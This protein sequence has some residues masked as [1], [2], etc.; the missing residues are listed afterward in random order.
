MKKK[1]GICIDG[2]G[3]GGIGTGIF[4]SRAKDVIPRAD[5]YAGTSVGAIIASYLAFGGS[6]GDVAKLIKDKAPTIFKKPPFWDIRYSALTYKYPNTGA[7]SVLKSLFGDKRM[8]DSP[9]PLYITALDLTRGC[10][11]VF[12]RTD[13]IPVWEAVLASMSAPTYF[14]QHKD[15]VDGGLGFN[16]PT[17]CGLA[18]YTA[19]TGHSVG[20]VAILNISSNGSCYTPVDTRGK[21]SPQILQPLLSSVM[22][23]TEVGTAF[24]AKQ[25][26]GTR[27]FRIDPKL[28]SDYTLDNCGEMDRIAKSW[29]SWCDTDL[30]EFIEW[31]SESGING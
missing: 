3:I 9:V 17:L 29:D 12:D 25:L 21:L 13:T 5:F 31:V 22:V 20:D 18:G 30:D 10:P 14:P 1:F 28:S 7:V 26:L 6:Y 15:F 16:N 23:A 11:K 19:N 27:Y 2:G 24:I 4:L 8:C